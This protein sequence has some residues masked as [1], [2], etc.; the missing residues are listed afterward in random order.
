MDEMCLSVSYKRRQHTPSPLVNLSE[1]VLNLWRMHVSHRHQCPFSVCFRV[2][3]PANAVLHKHSVT[4]KPPLFSTHFPQPLGHYTCCSWFFSLMQ[5]HS[6]IKT[7][8]IFKA[9]Q[10]IFIVMDV[11]YVCHARVTFSF[12][13]CSLF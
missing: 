12:F 10:N 9:K 13:I 1:S 3:L 7:S 8:Q 4:M 5:C 11:N 2:C 6:S